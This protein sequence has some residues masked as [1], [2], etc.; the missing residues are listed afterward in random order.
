[1]H[2]VGVSSK[3]NP[4]SAA[5][6]VWSRNSRLWP[7]WANNVPDVSHSSVATRLVCDRILMSLSLWS[8]LKQGSHKPGKLG[9]VREF[10]KPGKVMEFEIWSGNFL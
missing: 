6:T 5:G 3:T 7:L 8:A 2:R 10:C 4:V 1:M 9:I